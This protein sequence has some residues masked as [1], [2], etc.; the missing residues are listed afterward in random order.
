MHFWNF[1]WTQKGWYGGHLSL[2]SQCLTKSACNVHPQR[3]MDFRI[4]GTC[5]FVPINSWPKDIL[6]IWESTFQFMTPKHTFPFLRNLGVIQN[7]IFYFF[8]IL[9]I[10]LI[11]R[12]TASER[13]NVYRQWEWERKK[14]APS[15]GAWCGAQSQDSGITPWSE[16]RRLTT[17][18]PRRPYVFLFYPFWEP[19]S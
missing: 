17:E 7:D 5:G 12:E 13:G 10:Y 18:P 19:A 14:Q 16:G 3:G 1:E 6:R 11:E 15:R 4:L 2:F 8:K 9:F